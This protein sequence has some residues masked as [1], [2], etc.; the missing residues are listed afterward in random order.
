MELIYSFVGFFV[1]GGPF[2]Y[3]IL[4]VFAFGAAIAIERYITLTLVR[5]KNQSAWNRVQPSLM[6]GD[7]N[8]A[9]HEEIPALVVTLTHVT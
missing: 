8:E 7:F 6:N 1:T 3:P 5:A 4:I 2:M 9:R